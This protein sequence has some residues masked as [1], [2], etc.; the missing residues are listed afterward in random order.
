MTAARAVADVTRGVVLATIE[1]AVG[2]ERVFQA[3]TTEEVVRWWGSDETYRT[4]GWEADVRVGGR[5]RAEGV[6][7]DGRPFAVG[8]EYLSVE[9]PRMLVMTWRPAWEPDL[10]TTLT[11]RID[12]IP[13]GVRLTVRHEGFG[14]HREACESHTRGWELVLG[15][16]G[17]YVR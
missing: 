13:S 17:R 5:W 8:G 11:Y 4:T 7:A 6:N 1:L 15:W 3:L 10:S 12:A 2:A 14:A 16:L 9:A